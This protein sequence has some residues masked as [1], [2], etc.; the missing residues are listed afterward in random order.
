MKIAINL[1]RDYLGGITTSNLSLMHH[2]HKQDYEFVGIELANKMYMKGP[3]LFRSFAPELFDHH[4][5]NIH[6]L[7]IQKAITNRTTLHT[8]KSHYKDAIEVTRNILRETKPDV[9]FLSGTYHIPWIISVAARLEKIP[10]VLWYSGILTKEVEHYTETKK[11]LLAKIEYDIASAAT[12][13]IFPSKICKSVVEKTVLKKK[14]AR[15]F[16]IPN[17]LPR[18]FTET[19]PVVASLERHISAV[20]RYSRIKNFDRFFELHTLLQKQKWTHS[21]SF[22][23]NVDMLKKIVPKTI[24][25]LPPMT[26]EGLKSF[27]LSQ[28][29]VICPSTFETFGNVPMEAVSLGIPVL[30][31]DKMGCSE[32]LTKAGL[33]NM[34]ISFDDLEKVA[35]RVKE[36]CGQS[37]LPK[38]MN[39]IRRMLDAHLINE[40]IRAVI[41]SVHSQNL[42]STR[43]KSL[44]L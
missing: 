25:V 5:I 33:K 42:R 24:D 31:S 27:Y 4:I 34:I 6:H 12:S 14:V 43:K 32:V 28:G 26:P 38:Q 22:V 1:T 39:A 18:L 16:V 40:Q 13:I 23:T 21:A 10:I 15:A 41:S 17:P 11:K 29:L 20:G 9:V 36:L 19:T 30:V 44:Y 2:L 7:P 37:I 8:L 3:T 35:D